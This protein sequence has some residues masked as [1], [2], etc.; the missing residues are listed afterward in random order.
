MKIEWRKVDKEIY[1]PK[2]KPV[3]VDVPSYKYYTITGVGNPNEDLF[4]EKIAALYGLSYG[5]RMMHK[6][7]IVPA[8]FYEYTV[9]PL[10]GIW[11]ITDPSKIVDGKFDKSEL[12]YKIMIR[13][14]EFVTPA[15]AKENIERM[16]N[17]K[18]NPHYTDVKF[19]EI[20]DGHC[21]Q[22]LHIGAYDD[23]A[24]TFAVLNEYIE[25]NNLQKRMFEHKEIYLSRP[26]ADNQD[27]LKTVLRYFLKD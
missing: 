18:P 1:L 13:Q 15:L 6:N 23:E 20:S 11:G 19:E 21:V 25:K 7:G 26:T 3:E 22:M 5:I 8:G 24:K 4:K 14:P 2:T 17:K 9:Y 12:T 16:I 27:K 10:E